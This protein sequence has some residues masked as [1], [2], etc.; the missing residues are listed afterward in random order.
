[1]DVK[2]MEV[3]AIMR[4]ALFEKELPVKRLMNRCRHG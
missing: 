2:I 3:Y 4:S 1:M